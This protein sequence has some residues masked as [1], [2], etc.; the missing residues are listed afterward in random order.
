VSLVPPLAERLEAARMSDPRREPEPMSL[1]S[2]VVWMA[3]LVALGLL[4]GQ[5]L[6]A[7]F[8]W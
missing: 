2:A 1:V 6:G 3:I 4:I 8:G 7:V 5:A